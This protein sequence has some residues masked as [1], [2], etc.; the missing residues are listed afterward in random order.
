MHRST[1]RR[2]PK[3]ETI[4]SLSSA[5]GARA[6]MGGE[7]QRLMEAQ[8]SEVPLADLTREFPWINDG[9]DVCEGL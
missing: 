6:D 2:I 1:S 4:N 7:F 9:D 8:S 5:V 3:D